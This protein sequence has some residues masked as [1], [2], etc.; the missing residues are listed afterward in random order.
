MTTVAANMDLKVK[1]LR[2]QSK[3]RRNNR[4]E[5]FRELFQWLV[6]RRFGDQWPKTEEQCLD[7]LSN[8]IS[9]QVYDI[10]LSKGWIGEK[11]TQRYVT[12]IECIHGAGVR[13]IN[14]RN[15]R[16]A[17]RLP[18]MEEVRDSWWGDLIL[19]LQAQFLESKT[20]ARKANAA[21]PTLPVNDRVFRKE[22]QFWTITFSGKTIRMKDSKGLLYLSYILSSPGREFQA[23]E[24]FAAAEGRDIDAARSSAGDVLDQPALNQY[25]ARAADIR[26]ELE[27]ARANNDV[28]RIER[29]RTELELLTDQIASAKG[30]GGRRRSVG[31]TN[32][33]ARKAVGQSITRAVAQIRKV[34]SAL[35]QFLKRH[36]KLGTSLSYSSDD[37]PWNS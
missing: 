35:A 20:P 31:D 3:L 22:G 32:E 36:L 6:E 29:L 26:T 7:L 1:L 30:L 24:L 12:Y 14:E 28:A 13:A 27:E 2:I 23:T 17:Y 4:K 19:V 16:E 11:Q 15:R 10:G 34:H 37:T 5:C 9:Q 18:T 21:S 25:K 33:R 8:E